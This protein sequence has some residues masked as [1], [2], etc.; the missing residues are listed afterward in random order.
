MK[1]HPALTYKITIILFLV[2]LSLTLASMMLMGTT[3]RYMQDDY[4]YAASL[5]GDFWQRQVNAYLTETTFSGNRFSLTLMTGVD[6]LFGPGFI[7]V[8]PPL[9]LLVWLVFLYFFIRQIPG[10]DRKEAFNRLEALTAAAALEVFTMAM[11]PNWVQVY[12]WRAGMLPYLAPLVSGTLL[13]GLLARILKQGGGN[14]FLA[15]AVFLTAFLTGGFSEMEVMVELAMLALGML[16]LLLFGK[17]QKR[18]VTQFAL[19]LAGC[20]AALAL[21]LFSPMNFLR[22][23]RSYSEYAPLMQTI[24]NSFDGGLTFYLATFYRS[25]LYYA[26]A[27]LTFG[28]L[29]WMVADRM[30]LTVP[31]IQKILLRSVL[32]VISG[33]LVTVAAMIPGFYAESSYPS[34][35]ALIIPRFIS[36]LLGGGLG[37][38]LGIA[39]STI[40]KKG[41]SHVLLIIASV[42]AMLVDVFWLIDMKAQ[43]HPPAFPETRA[44]V[45]TH[46]GLSLAILAGVA[47]LSILLALKGKRKLALSLSLIL[48]IL[49]LGL[50]AARFTV[51]YPLMRER[52]V[53]W[54]GRDAQ[55]RQMAGSGQ[56][57][58]VVPAMNSLAGILELS[59]YSGFW[60]NNCA[61]A[62]Y[63]VHSISAVEPVLD[64]IQLSNP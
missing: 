3:A 21:I 29:A 57:D 41:A 2:V 64:P 15:I 27:L 10:L 42:A 56:T 17:W 33:Y 26:A 58:L 35:R 63:H 44:W 30:K 18:I 61:A 49:P 25:N 28:L 9:T 32:W 22:M 16:S 31:P 14:W 34:D 37:W 47:A 45:Q 12:F 1:N 40:K 38:M 60:V 24:L 7:R 13:M 19:A 23:Q 51:E 54:D 62:Y 4:C 53:L 36:L 46:I 11:A 6:E 39:F 20:L 48:M 50:T 59:D 43:F 55:I 5:R 8:V 52:A